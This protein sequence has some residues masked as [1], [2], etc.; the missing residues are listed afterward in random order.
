MNR[1]TL[2]RIIKE[3]F[4][5]VVKEFTDPHAED[6]DHVSLDDKKPGTDKSMDKI[7]A[8]ILVNQKNQDL[9]FKQY[10]NNLISKDD[11]IVARKAIQSK[12]AKLEASLTQGLDD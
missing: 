6:D 11:Y 3:E 9:L 12:R 8:A 1:Q 7:Y 2:L 10:K 4:Q 5:N